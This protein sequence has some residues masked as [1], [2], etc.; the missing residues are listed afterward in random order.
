MIITLFLTWEKL[1]KFEFFSERDFQLRSQYKLIR[2]TE[3]RIG[4]VF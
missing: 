2:E 1:L 4:A 3:I